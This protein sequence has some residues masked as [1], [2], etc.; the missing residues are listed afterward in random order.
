MAVN[1]IGNS[2][3]LLAQS[4]QDL[5]GQLDTLQTQLSTGKKSTVYSGMGINE[6]FAIF[7][8]A[9]LSNLSAFTTTM[10]NINTTI[11]TTSTAL[12]SFGD[13]AT[14]VKS[15]AGSGGA[16][17]TG[18]GQTVGQQTALLQLKTMLEMLNTQAGTTEDTQ[19]PVSTATPPPSGSAAIGTTSTA[20]AANLKAALKTAVGTLAS[21]SLAAASPMAASDKFFSSDATATGSVVNNK[22]PVP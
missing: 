8:R 12:Q 5:K 16:I 10:T 7:A 9:Q 13:I 11:D 19:L 3:F 17:V 18:T 22:A 21:T 1:S 6:G 20:T 14:Q 2:N 15:A 4:I